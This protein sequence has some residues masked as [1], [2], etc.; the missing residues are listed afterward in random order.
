MDTDIYM[1]ETYD[2]KFEHEINKVEQGCSWVGWSVLLHL[3][4]SPQLRLCRSRVISSSNCQR[5][6]SEGKLLS[7]R[8]TRRCESWI[9][10]RMLREASSPSYSRPHFSNQSAKASSFHTLKETGSTT[11]GWQIPLPGK[12]PQVTA[13]GSTASALVSSTLPSWLT[14]CPC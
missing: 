5:Q 3:S 6:F 10:W 12:T 11:V 9:P 13:T 14:M 2:I 1:Y 7:T 4:V 8:L